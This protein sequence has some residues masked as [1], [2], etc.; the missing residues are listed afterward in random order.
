MVQGSLERPFEREIRRE[1]PPEIFEELA[2][3]QP[4]PEK[5]LVT[6]E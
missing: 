5:I 2:T 4:R 1:A 6:Y 3:R